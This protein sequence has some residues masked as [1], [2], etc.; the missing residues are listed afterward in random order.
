M[1]S[2]DCGPTSTVGSVFKSG[3]LQHL[4]IRASSMKGCLEVAF[5]TG[6][7]GSVP[8][9]DA[10]VFKHMIYGVLS[11]SLVNACMPLYI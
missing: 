3:P 6:E 5:Y 1:S 4:L 9:E 2:L 11:T 7:I 10:S 8:C